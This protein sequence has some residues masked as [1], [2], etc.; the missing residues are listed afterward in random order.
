MNT[1]LWILQGVLACA[2]LGL[3]I[4]KITQPKEKLGHN[5]GWVNDF[6]SGTVKTIGL[7]EVFAGIGL[8][9]PAV[10]DIAPMLTA[11]AAIG[12]VALMVGAGITHA[13]RKELPLIVPTL[14]LA[15]VAAVAAW[16]RLGPYPL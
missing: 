3:G 2:F 10:L 9:L 5:M 13:R 14:V 1:A 12:L 4:L 6:A 8:I 11:L 16:G 7:L 15:A